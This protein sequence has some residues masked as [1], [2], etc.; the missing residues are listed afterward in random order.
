MKYI[1]ILLFCAISNVLANHSYDTAG[2]RRTLHATNQLIEIH[3]EKGTLWNK[4]K[5]IVALNLPMKSLSHMCAVSDKPMDDLTLNQMGLEDQ[6]QKIVHK[7]S[8]KTK[9]EVAYLGN[10]DVTVFER[11]VDRRMLFK[12]TLSKLLTDIDEKPRNHNM[13][14][15]HVCQMLGLFTS[16]KFP[17]EYITKADVVHGVCVLRHG[18]TVKQSFKIFE[19]HIHFVNN[20]NVKG[21]RISMAYSKDFFQLRMLLWNRTCITLT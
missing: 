4:I 10:H 12:K 19:S 3:D 1:Y 9:I 17:V 2:W 11:G 13:N 15:Q 20:G 16:T 8:D 5:E 6:L 18:L 21:E 7:G 14:F